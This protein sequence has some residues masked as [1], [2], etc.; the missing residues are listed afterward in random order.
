VI[1][2]ILRGI[3]LL[4]VSAAFA[5]SLSSAQPPLVGG[6]PDV[7]GPRALALSAAIGVAA[8]NEGMFLNPG[9]I[10][11][12]KRYSL[13]AG[14]LVDR[15]G[16]ETVGQYY[17]ASVVDSLTS[18]VALGFAYL[19]PQKGAFTGNAFDVVMAGPIAKD[20]YLGASVEYY[21]VRGPE[22]VNAATADAG[23]FWQVT[24]NV[25]FGAA[26]YNLVPIASDPVAPMGAGA[27]IGIGND[28]SFQV[29]ADW[30]ADFDRAGKTTNRY[31]AGV[32]VLLA[33]LVPVRA[34]WMKDDT[35]DAQ[36]ISLGAGLVTQSGI[37][38]DVGYRQDVDD[39]SARTIAATLKV[40]L[41]Q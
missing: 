24:E 6:I 7:V 35:L 15:R 10:A 8:G 29:T 22:D 18:P 31:A 21:R 26:G 25:S 39:A 20:L 16:G 34:G 13:E 3:A 32:E 5:P 4:A 12:R 2:R 11:A 38:L 41:F 1:A 23:I 36:W 37:A 40:F 33:R 28:R 19:R 14:L 30:R 9:A 17:G 27:G